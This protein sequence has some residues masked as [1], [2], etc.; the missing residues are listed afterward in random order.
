MVALRTCVRAIMPPR[1]LGSDGSL[2]ANITSETILAVMAPQ[3]KVS[4]G[5]H[6]EGTQHGYSGV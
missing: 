3:M 6:L 4:G 1:A 5:F 2:P